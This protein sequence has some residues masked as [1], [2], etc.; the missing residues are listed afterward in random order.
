MASLCCLSTS[1]SCPNV[2]LGCGAGDS[3]ENVFE[4]ASERLGEADVLLGGVW[5]GGLTR[6]SLG[7]MDEAGDAGRTD[8]PHALPKSWVDSELLS[9]R[10]L[11]RKAD[12]FVDSEEKRLWKRSFREAGRDEVRSGSLQETRPG[13][14][15]RLGEQEPPAET[16][17]ILRI[18]FAG[19]GIQEMTGATADG[20][21]GTKM[22]P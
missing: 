22:A 16:R 3:T 1:S 15:G 13:S 19:V 18:E 14:R 9:R 11:G 10:R 12:E 17:G 8:F 21:P 20:M 5:M 4:F 2:G 7:P 6:M